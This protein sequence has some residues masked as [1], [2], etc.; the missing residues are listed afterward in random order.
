[1]VTSNFRLERQAAGGRWMNIEGRQCWEDG[2]PETNSAVV[3]GIVKQRIQSSSG[4]W[5]LCGLPGPDGLENKNIPNRP[6]PAPHDTIRHYSRIFMESPTVLRFGGGL[7]AATW[8]IWEGDT[9]GPISRLIRGCGF[10]Y[11]GK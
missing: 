2:E 3:A 10:L 1:M 5:R 8:T 7:I 4:G 11:D 9:T 6:G